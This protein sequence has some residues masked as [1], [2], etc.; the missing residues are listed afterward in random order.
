MCALSAGILGL[1]RGARQ[2]GYVLHALV[3]QPVIMGV[4]Q[5]LTL[6]PQEVSSPHP[7]LRIGPASE[8]TRHGE[9]RGRSLFALAAGSQSG[10][11]T[12]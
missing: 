9:M 4:R 5:G 7:Y 12:G 10:A 1:P 2:L 8:V 6:A 11:Q 3:A